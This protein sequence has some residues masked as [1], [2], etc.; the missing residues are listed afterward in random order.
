MLWIPLNVD[1][2]YQMKGIEEINSIKEDNVDMF[3]R[4]KHRFKDCAESGKII[5]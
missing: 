4:D 5:I 2:W 1:R 3:I